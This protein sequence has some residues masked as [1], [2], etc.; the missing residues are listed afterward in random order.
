MVASTCDKRCGGQLRRR[1]E[2]VKTLAWLDTGAGVLNN[3]SAFKKR[4][5]R[6]KNSF[7]DVVCLV[8]ELGSGAKNDHYRRSISSRR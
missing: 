3:E 2:Q 1:H 6:E 8:M 7:I 5:F 4:D